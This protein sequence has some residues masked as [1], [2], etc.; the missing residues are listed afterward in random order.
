MRN[1]SPTILALDFDGVIC[2]GLKEYFQTTQLAYNQ[3]WNR[4][5]QT[6]TNDLAS[7]FYRLRPVIETGWEMPVLLRALVLG[8]SEANILQDWPTIAENLVSSEQLNPK[9]IADKVDTIRDN[10][11]ETNLDGWLDL[12]EFYPGIVE[13]LRQIYASS[14]QIY[15]VTTKEGRFVKRLLGQ[16]GIEISANSLIGKECKQPKYQTLREILA[17]NNQTPE[18]LWF[19]EDRLKTLYSIEQHSDLQK[20]S[21]FLA[22]WGYNTESARKSASL[23]P[24]IHLL[25]LDRFCQDFASWNFPKQLSL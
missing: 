9:D 5:N 17:A 6:N 18:N 24:R 4:D 12:H 23:N 1:L 10:W 11:I 22:E 16:Q 8:F 25:S 19:V 3:L 2:D 15:I 14:T 21:L 20:V 13:R 7:S